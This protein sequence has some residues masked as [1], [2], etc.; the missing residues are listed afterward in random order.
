V[1]H[2]DMLRAARTGTDEPCLRG[3][4]QARSARR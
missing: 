4:H 1:I 2:D 3:C